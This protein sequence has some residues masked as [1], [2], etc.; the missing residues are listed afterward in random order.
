[1]PH[2]ACAC[3]CTFT[4]IFG[5]LAAVCGDVRRH[6]MQHARQRCAAT[7]WCCVHMCMPCVWTCEGPVCGHARPR[8][9]MSV[10]QRAC[11]WRCAATCGDMAI[12]GE[13]RRYGDMRRHAAMRPPSLPPPTASMHLHSPSHSSRPAA[14][15]S[16]FSPPCCSSSVAPPLLLLFC[17][18]SVDMN[19]SGL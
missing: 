8:E 5:R 13:I 1:V 19:D 18:S 17:C 16:P 6:A 3:E 9:R 12:C 11:W 15:A 7:C 10:F 4:C 2:A 14:L